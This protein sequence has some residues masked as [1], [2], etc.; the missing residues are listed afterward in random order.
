[1]TLHAARCTLHAAR[2]TLHAARCTLH[3]ARCTLHEFLPGLKTSLMPGVH[4]AVSPLAPS[5]S[6][7]CLSLAVSSREGT[8]LVRRIAL[9]LLSLV[10]LAAC[11]DATRPGTPRQASLTLHPVFPAGFLIGGLSINRAR[12]VVVRPPSAVLNDVTVPFDPEAAQLQV[13]VP[14]LLREVQESLSVTLE[15][16]AGAQVLF[17][18]TSDVE[19]SAGPG[20]PQ[21]SLPLTYV[22]PGSQVAAI[23]IGPIDSI[24]NL[25]DSVLFRVSA[26]D[27]SQQAVTNFYVSWS[28]SDGTRGDVNANGLVRARNTRSTVMVRAVTPT[29][30]ADSTPLTLVPA[31]TSLVRISGDQQT[32]GTGTPLALPFVVRVLANDGLGVKG[33]VVSFSALTGGGSVVP[34]TVVSDTGGFATA[35]GTLGATP[36]SNTYQALVA[37]L[38][39]VGFTATSGGAVPAGTV[40]SSDVGSNSITVL[41]TAGPTT[42]T[43]DCGNVGASCSEPRNPAVNPSG[44]LFAVP[45]RFSDN[46]LLLDPTVPDFVTEVSDTSFHEPYAAAFTADGAEVWVANKFAGGST[47]GTVSIVNVNTGTVVAVVRDTSFGSPEGITITGNKAYVANRGKNT[48]SVVNVTT[49]TV[50]ARIDLVNATPRHLVA[51]PNGAFV[52]A[53]TSTSSVAKIQT[54][55]DVLLVEIP[56][57]GF[58]GSRN[59]AVR[60]DGA[61]VYA[62]M[63]NGDV[64]VI[65]VA[66]D[67]ASTMSFPNASSLYGVA[68]LSDG[69]LGLVTDENTNEIFAFNPATNAP[70]VG[71]P[72]PVAVGFTPRGIVAH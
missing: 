50:I 15:L 18:A 25:R 41:T 19:V 14:V 54:S 45:Y 38:P 52:Y 62:A 39:P 70:I 16:R 13:S 59:L 17:S 33:T 31:P 51:T 2:C 68:V 67:A 63:Q 60:P 26:V 46:L 6:A 69:S 11:E 43:V 20:S 57:A 12:I 53:S 55:N 21:P 58:G 36:G 10:T 35:A 44:T 64:A 72:Y 66:T 40:I 28:L 9:G 8:M 65:N 5:S 48:I 3:A 24:V 34:P 7:V 27:S 71:G 30:I 42:T 1:M 49:R 37:G 23:T 56:T 47:V 32:G 4:S 61:F 29:G 22:G